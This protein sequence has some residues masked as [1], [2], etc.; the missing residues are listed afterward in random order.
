MTETKKALNRKALSRQYKETRRHMGVFRVCNISIHKSLIGSSV[1]LTAMLNRQ[2]FQLEMGAHPNQ[3]L[4]SDWNKMGPGS[5]KFEELDILKQPENQPDYDP[6][7]DL[8][9]LEEM[10][11][12]KLD[13]SGESIYNAKVK[14]NGLPASQDFAR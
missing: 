7:E 8:R 11:M 1:D 12:Q 4:Q 9:V 6:T 5:F 2:R 3:A 13:N 14:Q 10:W